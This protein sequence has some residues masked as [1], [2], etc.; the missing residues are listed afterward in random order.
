MS[1][2]AALSR[3]L[4]CEVAAGSER[5]VSGGSINSCSRFDSERGPLFVKHGDANSLEMFR[6]EAD[7]LAELSRARAVRVPEVLAVGEHDGAAFLVLE[8]IDLRSATASSETKLGEL[9]A[10]QHRATQDKFGWHRDNTI[11]STPQSNQLT[12]DWIDFLREQRLH[13]QLALAKENGASGEIIDS[14]HRLCEQ[15][16]YFFADY[17][18]SRSL[19]HGDLW[20]GNWGAD[21]SG[22]PVLFDPAVYFGDREADL[23]MTRLFGGFGASFYSAYQAAWPLD[24]GAAARVPLYNLYHVL[25]HF[26]LF[27]GGYMRQALTM[28]QRLLAELE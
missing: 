10:T 6:A 4:G 19:L 9:L 8:W 16:E 14:G 3:T 11:G 24:T 25:N 21:A 15:L 26:N 17:R 27:G 1:L 7:G 28:I 18:P 13:P 23:A 22:R 12:A 5:E 2:A 20:G